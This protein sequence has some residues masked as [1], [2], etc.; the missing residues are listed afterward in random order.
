MFGQIADDLEDLTADVKAGRYTWVGN[1]LLAAAP[2]EVIPP[3]ARA[4]RLGEGFMRPERGAVVFQQLKRVA[5]AAGADVP[6]SAPRPIRAMVERLVA[7][8]D[9][10]CQ[11]MHE[12]RVRWVFRG[13]LASSA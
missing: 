13:V 1:V 9:A 2:G 3:E 7:T 11:S 4:R 6:G 10:L 5:R 12:A 8:P